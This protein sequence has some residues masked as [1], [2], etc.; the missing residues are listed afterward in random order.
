MVFHYTIAT[1]NSISSELLRVSKHRSMHVAQ[2]LNPTYS[3]LIEQNLLKGNVS[4]GKVTLW[5]GFG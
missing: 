1:M 4:V 2:R 5:Y 3:N